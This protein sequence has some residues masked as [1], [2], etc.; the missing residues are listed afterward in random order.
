VDVFRYCHFLKEVHTEYRQLKTV[1]YVTVLMR[2]AAMLYVIFGIV[3][4]RP[5]VSL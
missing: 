4:V 5:S 3:V 1:C 2:C